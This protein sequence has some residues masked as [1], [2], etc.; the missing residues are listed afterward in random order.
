[1]RSTAKA[2]VVPSTLALCAAGVAFASCSSRSEGS[3]VEPQ[4]PDAGADAN[5][6]LQFD[7]LSYA[8]T[9]TAGFPAA[10]APQTVSL[11]V[12]YVSS[13]PQIFVTLRL[14]TQSGVAVGI[15]NG[16]LAAWA[17]YADQPLVQAPALPSIGSWHHVEFVF[18]PSDAGPVDTLY[19]DGVVSA[20]GNALGDNRTPI[21]SWVGSFDGLTQLF[22]GDIDELRIWNL[23]RTGAGVLQEMYGTIGPSEPGLV[24]YF[25]CNEVL[26]TRVP[27]LS[28]NGNDMTLGGGVVGRMPILVPSNVP[29]AQ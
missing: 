4:G 24:A 26:G 22:Q 8:T 11:W 20:T 7:G 25:D 16:T 6:A 23:A 1:L 18:D 13:N 2:C 5:F 29:P 21:S 9:G 27:D 12:R 10:Y 19:V 15:Q 17:T 14:D 3:N 28:G